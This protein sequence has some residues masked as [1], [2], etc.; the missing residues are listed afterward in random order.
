MNDIPKVLDVLQIRVLDVG[1]TLLGGR[2][3][4]T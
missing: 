4:H 2:D 1:Q 3:T